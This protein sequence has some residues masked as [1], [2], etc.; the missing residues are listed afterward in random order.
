MAVVI[1]LARHGRKKLPFYRIVVADK[2]APRDGKFL[3]MIGTL[4]NIVEPPAVT[5]KE[6]RV[7]YW[8]GVGAQPSDTVAQLIEKRIPG[9]L[10]QLTAARLEKIKAARKKRKAKA[11]KSGKAAKAAKTEKKAPAKK[12]APKKKEASA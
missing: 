8:V 12:A 1:R 3:E 2:D 11:G 4:S 9:F 7:K 10:S 5:L 6:D